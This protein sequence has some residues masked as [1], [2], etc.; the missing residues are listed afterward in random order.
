MYVASLTELSY[1]IYV[2]GETKKECCDNLIVAFQKYVEWYGYSVEEWVADCDEDFASYN[3]DVLRFLET[4]YGY[5]MYDITKGY[6]FGW[7]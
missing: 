5:K 3:Y 1:D 2:V 7:E 4:Y 6:A